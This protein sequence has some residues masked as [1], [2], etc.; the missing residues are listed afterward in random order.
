MEITE[1]S[2]RKRYS[3]MDTEELIALHQ[4]GDLTPLASLV[5]E[6][7]INEKGLT[8]DERTNLQ[9]KIKRESRSNVETIGFGWWKTW[10]WLNLIAATLYLFFMI[11]ENEL[12]EIN[13]DLIGAVIVYDI[14]FIMVLRYNK[15]AFLIATVISLNPLI[16]IINGIYLQRRWNCPVVNKSKKENP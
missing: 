7:I 11:I 15:Y 14:L 8:Q 5:I 12:G 6:S 10:A 13:T 2:L 16:W 9:E 4:S 1:A 3:E